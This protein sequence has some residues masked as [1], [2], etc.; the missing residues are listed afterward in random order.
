MKWTHIG[1]VI[2]GCP[3][4]RLATWF[5][6][7]TTGRI[8][9][10]FGMEVVPLG[11]T[12]RSYFQFSTIGKKNG[13]RRNLCWMVEVWMWRFG[14]GWGPTDNC[15]RLKESFAWWEADVIL[16]NTR[17]KERMRKICGLRDGRHLYR[18]VDFGYHGYFGYLGNL[19]CLRHGYHCYGNEKRGFPT[20]LSG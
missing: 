8:W 18:L 17:C 2:S 13:G 4:A 10:K 16:L 7:R 9:K 14:Y 19:R 1:L 20:L 15:W 3:P 6:S 11:T 12:L 5:N